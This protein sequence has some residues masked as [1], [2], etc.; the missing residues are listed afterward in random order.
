MF[1][2]FFRK[3]PTFLDNVE[4]HGRSEQATYGDVTRVHCKLHT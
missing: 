1:N 3:L 2:N 4:K